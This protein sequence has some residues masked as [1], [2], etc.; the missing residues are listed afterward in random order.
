MTGR[1]A[2]RAIWSPFGPL[3]DPTDET[4]VP[5]AAKPSEP[6]LMEGL[7]ALAASSAET[8]GTKGPVAD[9]K[10][11]PMRRVALGGLALLMALSATALVPATPTSTRIAGEIVSLA[12]PQVVKSQTTGMVTSVHVAEGDIVARGDVLFRLHRVGMNGDLD[13]L[14]ADL[15]VLEIRKLRLDAEVLGLTDFI[16]PPQLLAQAPDAVAIERRRLQSR[17]LDQSS[18]LEGA[19]RAMEEARRDAEMAE[20]LVD[21]DLASDSDISLATVSFTT[22]SQ[23]YARVMA[24]IATERDTALAETEAQLAKIRAKVDALRQ[25]GRDGEITSPRAGIVAQLA[26]H[27]P[28][29]KLASGDVVA[30]IAPPDPALHLELLVDPDTKATLFPGQTLDVYLAAD[31]GSAGHALTAVMPEAGEMEKKAGLY[32][33]R[34]PL[35]PMQIEAMPNAGKVQPGLSAYIEI[36]GARESLLKRFDS[37][38]DDRG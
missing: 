15:A 9:P 37:W 3:P 25:G 21:R 8:L 36:R 35:D 7:A 20:R 11:N 16:V 22:A 14:I 13:Q 28:G 26:P 12:V 19:R 34:L 32:L 10:P 1:Y 33:L 31:A 23:R 38:L 2:L 18:R 29:A 24:Q 17:H 6:T 30:Q 27:R 5:A 4:E